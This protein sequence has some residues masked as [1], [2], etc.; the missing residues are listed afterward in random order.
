MLKPLQFCHKQNFPFWS[1]SE[2]FRGSEPDAI[3][4]VRKGHLK[5]IQN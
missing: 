5:G 3:S 4:Q 1:K 2:P